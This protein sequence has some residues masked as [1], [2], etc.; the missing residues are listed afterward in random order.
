VPSAPQN[1]GY[2]YGGHGGSLKKVKRAAPVNMN[3]YY[4][5]NSGCFDG[6]GRVQMAD[7]SEKYTYQI[8]KGDEVVSIN[9]QIAKVECVVQTNIAS[10]KAKLVTLT[11]GLT[12][13]PY[14]PIIYNGEWKFPIDIATPTLQIC[15]RIYNFVLSNGH[16]MVINGEQACTLG[17]GFRDNKVI[18]HPYFGTQAIINDLKSL[19]GWNSGLITFRDHWLLVNAETNMLGGLDASHE[20]FAM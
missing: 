15:D 11:S 5:C 13:T 16:T 2:G 9:G 14:H 12:L 7:G 20:I 10:G 19:N 17:H 1:R 4:N 3:R 18:D 8:K 6:F